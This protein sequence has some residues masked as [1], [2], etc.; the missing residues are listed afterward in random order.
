M[1]NFAVAASDEVIAK[2][3]RLLEQMANPREKKGETLSRAFDLL[4]K[5]LD[6]EVMK[7]GG[8]DV[9]AMDAALA[10]IRAQFF[11]A[12]TGKEEIVAKKNA[13][14][15]ELKNSRYQAEAALKKQAED[16]L[17]AGKQAEEASV[18]AQEEAAQLKKD[19]ER[20]NELVKYIDT[21]KAQL[22]EA[23]EKNAQFPALQEEK[24][25]LAEALGEANRQ[26]ETVKKD[27]ETQ[28]RE[29][30]AQS[31]RLVSDARKDAALEREKALAARERELHNAASEK[32]RQIDRE[33]V[34]L[35]MENETLRAEIERLNKRLDELQETK[36]DKD[37]IKGGESVN[38]NENTTEEGKQ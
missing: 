12:V 3:N 36:T 28:M 18:K 16:A 8:V 33:N 23:E 14:I 27:S 4:A 25:K 38:S 24:Q 7:S 1:A 13:E 5:H 6:G 17:A 21:L 26:I 30:R 20:A 2:G 10:N 22:T 9:E 15:L 32:I 11:A 34:R 37:V 19:L 31:E 29:L 35:Q